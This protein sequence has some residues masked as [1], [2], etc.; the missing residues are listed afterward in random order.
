MLEHSGS[1]VA[2]KTWWLLSKYTLQIHIFLSK[3][4]LSEYQM[5]F[6]LFWLFLQENMKGISEGY[7]GFTSSGEGKLGGRVD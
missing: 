2:R 5:K 1:G 6:S 7:L 4:G 3:F